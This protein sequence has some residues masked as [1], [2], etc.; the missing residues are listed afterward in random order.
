MWTK[1]N[2]STVIHSNNTLLW[3]NATF[4]LASL[5]VKRQADMLM[6]SMFTD[7]NLTMVLMTHP[8]RSTGITII[9]HARGF[10]SQC[11]KLTALLPP[12]I[13]RQSLYFIISVFTFVVL[14]YALKD[15]YSTNFLD[16]LRVYLS[17]PLPRSPITKAGRILF[18]TVL[19]MFLIIN[20]TWHGN[21]PNMLTSER[22]IRNIE[23]IQ[24]INDLGYTVRGNDWATSLLQSHGVKKITT[25][26]EDLAGCNYLS[27]NEAFAGEDMHLRVTS[28]QRLCHIPKKIL[29]PMYKVYYIRPAWPLFTRVQQLLLQLQEGGIFHKW[30]VQAVDQ[31]ELRKVVKTSKYQSLSLKELYF[32]FIACFV[33]LISSIIIFLIEILIVKIKLCKIQWKL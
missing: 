3:G 17:L 12:L 22:E 24:D 30:F 2:A 25:N 18:A 26:D 28:T 32:I 23:T 33:G 6:V 29:I 8:T 4:G 7:L 13:F 31:F 20:A 11:Q 1:L 27:A 5:I 21:L 14:T 10:M 9:S 19:I 15:P 16:I